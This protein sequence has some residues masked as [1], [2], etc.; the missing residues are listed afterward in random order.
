MPVEIRELI[1]RTV[2]EPRQGGSS[3]ADSRLE[4]PTASRPSVDS[5]D[6]VQECVREVLR[7]LAAQRER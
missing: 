5:A 3:Q 2:V 7:I 6:I 4:P 1:I